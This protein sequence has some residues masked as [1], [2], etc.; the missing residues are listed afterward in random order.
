MWLVGEIF[1]VNKV[2]NVK[3]FFSMLGAV[4]NIESELKLIPRLVPAPLWHISLRNLSKID[5]RFA[6][7]WSDDP[8]YVEVLSKLSK[9]WKKLRR[10]GVCPICGI[11]LV[12]E[13]DEVWEYEVKGN[14]GVAK[15]KDL[16][17]ICGK[18]HL[19]R[20]LGFAKVMGRYS[21]A[22]SWLMKVNNISKREAE[23][24]SDAAFMQ[25]EQ[26]S[27][28]EKWNFDLSKLG[29]N[30]K[31]VEEFMN[32]MVEQKNFF[33]YGGFVWF[34]CGEQR[35]SDSKKLLTFTDSDYRQLIEKARELGLNV[36]EKELRF[37]ISIAKSEV[38]ILT[39]KWMIFLPTLD[40]LSLFKKIGH[41]A[42][43]TSIIGGKIPI[44]PGEEQKV[45]I[46]YTKNFLDIENVYEV[47]NLLRD[48]GVR[49]TMYYKPDLFTFAGIYSG[50]PKFRPYIYVSKK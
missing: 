10:E 9:W 15:L 41:I 49:E 29:I 11:D 42:K 17:P 45:I 43:E 19:V 24:V 39:G 20:H 26:L 16:Q 3:K 22:I 27:R 31:E 5:P 40:A 12:H 25:W 32:I 38:C 8:K 18:C 36:L 23:R 2:E 50:H 34:R 6:K 35:Q 13:I 21:E 47:A 44:T 28:I 30:F 7:I 37:A 14:H 33:I 1:Y 4:I 48:V 46:I